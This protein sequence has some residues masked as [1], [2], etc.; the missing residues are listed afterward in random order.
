[1]SASDLRRR[2]TDDLLDSIED[3]NY[4]S[5]AMLERFEAAVGDPGTLQRYI[6]VLMEKARGR[7]PNLQLL[8]RI[9]GLIAAMDRMEQRAAA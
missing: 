1:L 3:T 4:P 7:F 5:T 6:E 2:Y 9:N 8:D